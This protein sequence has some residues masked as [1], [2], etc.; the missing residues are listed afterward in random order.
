MKV[1]K[2][3]FMML[4]VASIFLSACG[5]AKT[6]DPY[7]S[8]PGN[9]FV[10]EAGAGAGLFLSADSDSG[11]KIT[12]TADFYSVFYSTNKVKNNLNLAGQK[13]YDKA[14]AF[15]L[16]SPHWANIP[17]QTIARSEMALGMT[18][19]VMRSLGFTPGQPTYISK[20]QMVDFINVGVLNLDV[21]NF[22]QC[23]SGELFYF[24]VI[25][26]FSGKSVMDRGLVDNSPESQAIIQQTKE[27]V[28]K[29]NITTSTD[30]DARYAF[31][32]NKEGYNAIWTYEPEIANINFNRVSQ[33][34]EPIYVVYVDGS[35][36]A[37]VTLFFS[38]YYQLTEA[39]KQDTQKVDQYKAILDDFNKITTAFEKDETIRKAIADSGWRPAQYNAEPSLEVLKPEWG[40]VLNPQ[41]STGFA[42]KYET[43]MELNKTY[44]QAIR[45][46]TINIY[47]NDD[48]GSMSP[49]FGIRG[50]DQ[51]IS[52]SNFIFGPA[53]ES[54]FLQSVDGDINK[55]YM[56][57][58]DCHAIGTVEGSNTQIL[59]DQISSTYLGGGTSMFRCGVDALN[60]MAQFK[61]MC[62]TTHNCSIIFMTDGVDNDCTDQQRDPCVSSANFNETRTTLILDFIP[63]YTIPVGGADLSQIEQINNVIICRDAVSDITAMIDCFKKIKGIR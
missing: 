38:P 20:A 48:S 50:R 10:I 11:K 52:A 14:N 15:V 45:K 12:D 21:C 39:D 42:P 36:D 44:T 53:A 8:V 33:G 58:S 35:I 59:A 49:E 23:N 54:E 27:L 25:N 6:S 2:S 22:T 46:P 7:A 19:D 55:V 63:V 18:G 4:I 28:D 32:D 31:L 60:D 37:S 13:Q 57:D 26:H 17:G 51:L 3:V 62:E 30:V 29:I 56:F 9:T 61:Q 24:T 34:L 41:T 40:F 43:A 47:I 16:E 5:G 1:F